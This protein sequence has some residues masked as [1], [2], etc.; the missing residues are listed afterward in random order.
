MINPIKLDETK[1]KIPEKLPVLVL[2]DVVAFPDLTWPLLVGRQK[3]VESVKYALRTDKLVILISQ[4]D[5]NIED[6]DEEDIYSIGTVGIILRTMRVRETDDKIKVLV[7]GL[8]KVRI[9][10]IIETEPHWMA[11]LVKQEASKSQCDISEREQLVLAVK[12]GLDQLIN[13]GKKFPADILAF[14]ENLTDPEKLAH[15]IAANIGLESIKAQDILEI[16]DPM[17]KLKRVKEILDD[18]I[19]LFKEGKS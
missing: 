16:D 9:L 11:T 4:K 17:K 15:V 8:C 1:T 18:Q 7:Q 2:R 14:I 19:S 12:E 13:Y 3:S 10:D 6:P 5:F